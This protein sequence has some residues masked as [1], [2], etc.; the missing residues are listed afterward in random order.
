MYEILSSI[1]HSVRESLFISLFVGV[2]LYDILSS[3]HHSV[4]TVI[5][6][7]KMFLPELNILGAKR[8][9]ELHGDA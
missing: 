4:R 6:K 3:I 7:I 2:V 8:I 5:L 9:K 1:R